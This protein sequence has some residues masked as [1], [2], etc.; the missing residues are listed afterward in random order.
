[1]APVCVRVTAWIIVL[2]F[3]AAPVIADVIADLRTVVDQVVCVDDGS[4]DD[5]AARPLA[6][7]GRRP[8]R[9]PSG[10]QRR[11]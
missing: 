10:V 4:R 11:I 1:M 2:A 5:T 9:I 6:G 8:R 3:N 7:G